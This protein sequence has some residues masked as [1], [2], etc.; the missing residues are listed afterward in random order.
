MSKRNSRITATFGNLPVIG[1]GLLT[2]LAI[3][4][5]QLT[6]LLVVYNYLKFDYYAAFIALCFLLV[7][8][9]IRDRRITKSEKPA[10]LPDNIPA[11]ENSRHIELLQLLTTRELQTLK[12]I[13]EGKTNKEIA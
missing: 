3:I 12:L 10:G 11:A 13:S 8:F 7:G 2:A 9:F 1:M 4:F 5:F 6:S